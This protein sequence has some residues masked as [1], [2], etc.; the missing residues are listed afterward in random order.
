VT[1]QG[2]NTVIRMGPAVLRQIFNRCGQSVSNAFRKF[3]N[4]SDFFEIDP[5]IDRLFQIRAIQDIV[6]EAYVKNIA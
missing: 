1:E 5:T 4:K 6:R 2:S 3:D